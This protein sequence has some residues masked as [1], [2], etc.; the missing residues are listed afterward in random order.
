MSTD[1]VFTDFMVLTGERK[2]FSI[3]MDLTK[4][5]YIRLWSNQGELKWDNERFSTSDM[6]LV[7][8]DSPESKEKI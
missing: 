2:P 3:S 4:D 5:G 1:H 7:L 6:G 8:A